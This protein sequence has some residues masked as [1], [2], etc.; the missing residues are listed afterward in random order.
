[1]LDTSSQRMLCE[2]SL[3]KKL[4]AIGTKRSMCLLTLSSGASPITTDSIVIPLKI[5]GMNEDRI[6]ELDE[7]LIV[8]NIPLRAASTPF[9]KEL[10]YMENSGG[11]KTN[12]QAF[13]FVLRLRQ[14]YS[15]QETK[16]GPEGMPDTIRNPL[17][18]VLFGPSPDLAELSKEMSCMHV[19]CI[20][21]EVI[22]QIFNERF[23]GV[24]PLPN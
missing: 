16:Y 17:D 19:G 21:K 13:T 4:R 5:C 15:F 23:S 18:W 9:N 12:Q 8:P 1:M 6:V 24:L 14:L 2:A 7:V 11:V 22:Y 10:R 3:A 20:E